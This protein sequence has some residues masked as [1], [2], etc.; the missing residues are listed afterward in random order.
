MG[1]RTYTGYPRYGVGFQLSGLVPCPYYCCLLIIQAPHLGENDKVRYQA[2]CYLAC[3]Q[4]KRRE[5]GRTDL[6]VYGI[7][8]DGFRY[9]FILLTR[10]NKFEF[11]LRY[12]YMNS[13]ASL[14]IIVEGIAHVIMKACEM[15][16]LLP[17]GD[18]REDCVGTLRSDPVIWML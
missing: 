15:M 17:E 1:N 3:L 8:A 10:D 6:D 14:R 5:L 11:S 7:V 16:W 4:A 12:N 13:R 2:L 18:C 9:L